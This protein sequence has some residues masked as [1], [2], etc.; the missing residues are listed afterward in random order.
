MNLL[1]IAVIIFVVCMILLLVFLCW[2]LCAIQKKYEEVTYNKD[3]RKKDD[4]K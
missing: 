4:Q 3:E 1:N 2:I